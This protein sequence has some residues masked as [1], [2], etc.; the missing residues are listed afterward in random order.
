VSAQRLQLRRT[1]GSSTQGGL[2]GSSVVVLYVIHALTRS[3]AALTRPHYTPPGNPQT[4]VGVPVRVSVGVAL[5]V[6]LG[7]AV[8]LSDAGTPPAHVTAHAAHAPSAGPYGPPAAH[9]LSGQAARVA[10]ARPGPP[11][12]GR[13]APGLIHGARS[14]T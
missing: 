14:Y 12:W 7:D 5:G 13:P 2:L 4:F 10:P 6:G 1:W 8:G 3:R 11:P 9:A